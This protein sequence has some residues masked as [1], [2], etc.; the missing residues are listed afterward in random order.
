M[1]VTEGTSQVGPCLQ[2]RAVLR[3]THSVDDLPSAIMRQSQT[4]NSAVLILLVS[5][6]HAEKQAAPRLPRLQQVNSLDHA[7]EPN[8]RITTILERMRLVFVMHAATQFRL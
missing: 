2:A 8:V 6:P 3:H 4:K 7:V 5:G 1:R